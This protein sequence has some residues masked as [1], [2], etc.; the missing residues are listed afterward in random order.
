M[1]DKTSFGSLHV[2]VIKGDTDICE[3][4]VTVPIL[5]DVI[6]MYTSY[7]TT[8]RCSSYSNDMYKNYVTAMKEWVVYEIV[9]W[10]NLFA[11]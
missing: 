5:L 6:N 7:V 11:I 2:Y 4:S 3:T 10:K 9:F 8:S 1:L